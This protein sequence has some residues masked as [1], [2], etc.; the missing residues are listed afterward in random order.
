MRYIVIV[1]LGLL[2]CSPSCK[3][4]DTVVTPEKESFAQASFSE[5]KLYSDDMVRITF[6]DGNSQWDFDSSAFIGTPDRWSTPKIKTKTNGMLKIE[7]F[8]FSGSFGVFLQGEVSVQLK[9][10]WF[11]SFEILKSNE[12]ASIV[13]SNCDGIEEF[14]L[15]P[16]DD[17]GNSVF[18][19]WRG[20]AE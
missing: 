12:D 10:N 17:E 2:M 8:L 5:S 6:D 13:C 20:S 19:L 18:V 7:F 16:R 15:S 11:W 9:A 3:S 14:T 1:M 4:D